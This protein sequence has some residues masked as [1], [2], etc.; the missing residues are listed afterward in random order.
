[1]QVGTQPVQGRIAY[2]RA[3]AAA[4]ECFGLTPRIRWVRLAE[5]RVDLRVLEVGEGEGEGAIVLLHGFSLGPAH[6]GP[7]LAGLQGRRLIALEMPGH[8]RS[9]G[10]DFRGIDLR[11]WFRAAL[12]GVL[13]E[14]GLGSVH[15]IGHSQG[16]MLGLFLALDA[17]GRVRSLV[18]IG[19]P[20]VAFGANLPGMRVLARPGLG[21][22]LLAMPKPDRFYRQILAG[23]VG[24]SALESM[25]PEL[26]RATYLGVRRRAFGTTVSTYLREMFRGAEV[27]PS[28]YVLSN[29]ERAT[30]QPPVL[31]ILGEGDGQQEAATS[32]AE[33]VNQ[34]R[35]GRFE[36]VPG[37][38]EP[39]MADPQRTLTLI[40]DFLSAT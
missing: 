22:L 34:M 4:F 37:G 36:P 30:M 32:T 24:R 31:V 13:D 29:A 14:L 18:A 28:R 11:S 40:A 27:Q 19:T 33:Q 35:Q 21:P 12:V 25:P 3:E 8:G 26:V 9:S 2:E 10:V 16:A 5:P 17:P 20:A 6:W 7:L 15:L 39:W 23:T 1:M 38:H